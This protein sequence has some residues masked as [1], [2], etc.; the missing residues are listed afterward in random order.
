VIVS[1][2]YN[3]VSRVHRNNVRSCFNHQGHHLFLLILD[4]GDNGTLFMH[5]YVTTMLQDKKIGNYNF[6]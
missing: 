2:F 6:S 5:V 1:L 4:L 3:K